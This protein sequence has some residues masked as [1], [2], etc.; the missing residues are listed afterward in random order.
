MTLV[1]D[2]AVLTQKAGELTVEP[3]V[4]IHEGLVWCDDPNLM[5]PCQPNQLRPVL[6][7]RVSQLCR[8]ARMST[9]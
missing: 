7:Q 4:G 8:S 6:L 9:S 2:R 5:A 1:A 3:G